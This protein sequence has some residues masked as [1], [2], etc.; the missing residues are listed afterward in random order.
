MG[1]YLLPVDV[2]AEGAGGGAL[3]ARRGP[4][5][6]FAP[7]SSARRAEPGGARAGRVDEL[8]EIVASLRAR[9]S[10]AC[11]PRGGPT[12][13]R[14]PSRTASCATPARSAAT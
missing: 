4:L 7:S 9:R 5:P 10:T 14:C 6:R 11:R 12:S 1:A 13:M 2:G 3:L 8:I